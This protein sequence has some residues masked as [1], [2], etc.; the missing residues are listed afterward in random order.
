MSN[1]FFN[2][3]YILSSLKTSEE[4]TATYLFDY[5]E[6]EKKSNEI[7]FDLSHIRFEGVAQL[8]EVLARI[9]KFTLNGEKPLI[10]FECH[11]D[12]EDGLF[13]KDGTEITWG[14]L[15]AILLK[16]NL[17]SRFNL[18]IGLAACYGSEFFGNMSPLHP[19][20]C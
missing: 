19:C 6:A 11:G 7:N 13:F 16:I 15:S 3:F 18:L 8:R 12:E 4:Y 14:E 17:S 2:H 10:H 1:G 9:N 20:P 5:I